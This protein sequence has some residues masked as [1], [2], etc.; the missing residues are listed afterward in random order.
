MSFL[1]TLRDFIDLIADFSEGVGSPGRI[2]FLRRLFWT[3]PNGNRIW[4]LGP[5]QSRM[6]LTKAWRDKLTMR[7]ATSTCQPRYYGQATI[8]HTDEYDAFILNAFPLAT[9]NFSLYMVLGVRQVF[10][11]LVC[12]CLLPQ[13]SL[14]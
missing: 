7:E 6:L 1:N 12:Y 4:S 2:V 5:E 14:P 11:W 8:I 13:F 9:L 3:W 10:S